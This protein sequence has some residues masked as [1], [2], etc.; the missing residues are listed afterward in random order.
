MLTAGCLLL[1]ISRR[2]GKGLE[3]EN[4]HKVFLLLGLLIMI[5]VSYAGDPVA[6]R[7]TYSPGDYWIF[8]EDGK[9]MKLEFLREEKDRYVFDKHGIPA[10]KD[11]NLTPVENIGRGY[12]GPIIKFPLKVGKSWNYEWKNESIEHATPDTGRIARYK[13]EA[14]EQLT[15]PAGTFWSF[16]IAATIESARYGKVFNSAIYWYAPDVKQ[17]IKSDW[18]RKILELKRY[19]IK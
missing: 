2:I 3:E 19:E 13:V 6:E 14:Y 15:V 9:N 18:K 8:T 12:P 5:D 7:P 10:A 16:K 11:F 4:M 17:I 1:S